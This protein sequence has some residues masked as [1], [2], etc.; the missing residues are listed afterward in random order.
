MPMHNHAHPSEHCVE[1]R[2]DA[3]DRPNVELVI[4]DLFGRGRGS[5]HFV[6]ISNTIT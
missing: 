2:E 4:F 6:S 3:E 1:G 5:T